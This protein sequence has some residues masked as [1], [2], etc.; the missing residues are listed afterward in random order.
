MGTKCAFT[1]CPKC[2]C[3][4]V[5]DVS[6]C[7]LNHS[8]G[9]VTEV[10]PY[11]S[12]KD[13]EEATMMLHVGDFGYNLGDNDGRIGDQ[14]FRN[15]E[16]VAA[17]VPYMVSIGNH[18][19]KEPHL[20]HFTERFRN[21]PA[22]SGEHVKTA[23]GMA[24]NNWYFSW[25]DGLVHYVAMSTE[26]YTHVGSVETGVDVIS[27]Y[28][29]L[30][31][32][33]REANANRNNTPWIVVHGHRAIYCSCDKDCGLG[34]WEMRDGPFGLEKL[35][36]EYGVDL[37]L[38]GHEHNYERNWP[39]YKGK[40]HQ[41]NIDPKATIYIVTGAAG[42]SELHEPFTRAQSVNPREYIYSLGQSHYL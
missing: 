23:N 13:G 26:L 2:T 39:T 30:E 32:D 14:F 12:G 18:E 9:L 19:D 42:C 7:A 35:F 38:N 24:P 20:S 34:A 17:Y 36:F 1:L 5:C 11:F 3:D 31:Q 21:M 15:I 40:S 28:E 16:Q 27:Q 33:L 41:S 10:G 4:T 29:W 6:T 25:D 37:F 8:A 22:N